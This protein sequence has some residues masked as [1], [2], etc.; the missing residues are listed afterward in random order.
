M[1]TQ[2]Y[3]QQSVLDFC[4]PSY[5]QNQLVCQ[6]LCCK[7]YSVPLQILPPWL[8]MYNYFQALY[9]YVTQ[10]SI[11]SNIVFFFPSSLQWVYH[12]HKSILKLYYDSFF[13]HT[14]FNELRMPQ[15]TTEDKG[16]HLPSKYKLQLIE[17]QKNLFKSNLSIVD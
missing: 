14:Q 7:K 2:K 6:S 1:K 10:F 11:S 9:S 13:Q 4:F 5:L 16:L 8:I 15:I 3:D 12:D 17:M